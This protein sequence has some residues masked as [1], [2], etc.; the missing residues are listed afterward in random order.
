MASRRL[1]S[2]PDGFPDALLGGG[3]PG[4]VEGATALVAVA[5]QADEGPHDDADED[6]RVD[7]ADL[8]AALGRGEEGQAEVADPGLDG[9]AV[10][11]ELTVVDRLVEEALQSTEQRDGRLGG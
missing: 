1:G 4:G 7:R 2:A 5:D 6:H 3:P 10:V 11:V 9:P 8:A